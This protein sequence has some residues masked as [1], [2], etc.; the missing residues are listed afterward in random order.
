MSRD[1]LPNS[2]N[3]SVESR[4]GAVGVISGYTLLWQSQSYLLV[5][6]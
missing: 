3:V 2:D 5:Y 1:S 6:F 4:T